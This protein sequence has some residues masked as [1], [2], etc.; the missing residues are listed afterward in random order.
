MTGKNLLNGLSRKRFSSS[1]NLQAKLFEKK[2][3]YNSV[4]MPTDVRISRIKRTVMTKTYHNDHSITSKLFPF[5]SGHWGSMTNG[6]C[7]FYA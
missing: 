1:V 7:L 3:V 5:E 4:T 6:D 2:W